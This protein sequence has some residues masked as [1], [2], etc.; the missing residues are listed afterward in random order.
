MKWGKIRKQYHNPINEA[1]DDIL[2]DG[3]GG[4]LGASQVT[5][6]SSGDE[7]DGEL[8]DGGEDRRSSYLPNLLGFP[9]TLPY[10]PLLPRNLENLVVPYTLLHCRISSW[11]SFFLPSFNL[12]SLSVRLLHPSLLPLPFYNPS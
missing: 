1:L 9:Q 7:A 4:E 3:D 8:R 2:N 11:I 12:L 6:E 5:Y 10:S